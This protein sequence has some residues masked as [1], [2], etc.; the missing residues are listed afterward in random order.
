[1]G[2]Y[3]DLVI[4]AIWAGALILALACWRAGLFETVGF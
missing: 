3:R 1:M 4:I 2:K